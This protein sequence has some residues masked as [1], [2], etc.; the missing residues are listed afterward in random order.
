M[1]APLSIFGKKDI[2][3]E[4]RGSAKLRGA[5]VLVVLEELFARGSLLLWGKL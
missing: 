1:L 4:A 2:V 3:V 5:L